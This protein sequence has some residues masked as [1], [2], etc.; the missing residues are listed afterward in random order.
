VP[1]NFVSVFH[2]ITHDFHIS[3]PWPRP[4]AYVPED[5]EVAIL[6]WGGASSVGQYAV[7]LLKYYGYKNVLVT[8]SPKHH[9]LLKELGA[10]SAIDYRSPNSVKEILDAAGGQVKYVLDCIGSLQGSIEAISKITKAG[11]IVA[12]ALPVILRDAT[13]TTE[14]VYEMDAQKVAEWNEGVEVIGIRTHFYTEVS[15]PIPS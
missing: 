7:Q 12:I 4:E 9:D 15:D 11:S 1:N 5:A 3:L 14:P 2:A 8:A 13:E 6:I 10:K